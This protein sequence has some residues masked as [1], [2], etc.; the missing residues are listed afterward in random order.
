MPESNISS[1][2]REKIALEVIRVLKNKF[3]DFP[4]DA[5][6]NRNAPFHEAFLNAFQE[7]MGQAIDAPY[8]ISLSSWLQGLNTTLGQSFFENVAHILSG[9]I[10]QEFTSANGNLLVISSEQ[11][12]V[13]SSIVSD[14]KNSNQSPNKNVEDRLIKEAENLG[15]EITAQEFSADNFVETDEYIEA[16]ELKSVRPNSGEMQGEKRKVLTGKA[17]LRKRYPEKDVTFYFGFP[18]DPWSQTTTG[19]D[20]QNF[21]ENLVEGRKY[22]DPTEVLLAEELWDKLSGHT[23]TMQE[24]LDII[25][26]IATPEFNTVYN[27][28]CNIDN[29]ENDYVAYI[30]RLNLWGLLREKRVVENMEI[31]RGKPNTRDLSRALRARPFNSKGEYNENRYDILNGYL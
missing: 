31:L 30:E 27:F 26:V 11:R 1:Q 15:E 18:F 22:L 19:F 28:L 24:L 3:D 8:L 10:K 2:K 29:L 14:L 21:L 25:N 4:N 17:A 7:K 6:G 9:G 16:I 13:I 23:N 20:K 12:N 5:A